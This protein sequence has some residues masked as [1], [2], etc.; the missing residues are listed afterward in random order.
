MTAQ[1]ERRGQL[2]LDPA[3][4]VC[5]L[6]GVWNSIEKDCEFVSTK[7]GH[8]VGFANTAFQPPSHRNKQL[9]ANRVAETVVHILEA[10]QIEEQHCEL[11][12]FVI[13]R[14]FDY[15]LQILSQQCAIGKI[16]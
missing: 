3:S 4:H 8:H 1:V 5:R 16:G 14:A 13:F 15:E 9:V 7:P 11:V 2:L 12:V 6:S 10:I